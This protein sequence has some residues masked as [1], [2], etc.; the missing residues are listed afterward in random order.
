M[1]L[2]WDFLAQDLQRARKALEVEQ[3]KATSRER[4]LQLLKS[5]CEQTRQAEQSLRSERARVLAE[6]SLLRD[7]V[8]C[9]PFPQS[10]LPYPIPCS[11]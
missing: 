4:D 11:F 10:T 8:R 2:G 3:S 5:D 7:R 6:L 9:A 1:V